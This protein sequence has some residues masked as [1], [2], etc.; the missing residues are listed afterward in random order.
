M[1]L[2]QLVLD[3]FDPPA[4]GF[5]PKQP[6]AHAGKALKAPESV[7]IEPPQK[8]PPP[9]PPPLSLGELLAPASFRHPQA[10]RE[11]RLGD[12]VVAYALQR[13]R[14]RSIG[15]TVSADGLSVRAPTGVTLAAVD[16]ALRRKS[17]WILRKLAEA[18]ERQQREEHARIRWQDGAALPYLGAPLTVVLDPAQGV[19]GVLRAAAAGAPAELRIGLPA[20]A[21]AA[22]VRDAVQAW[23]MHQARAHFT[24]RLD[25][26]APL[27]GVRWSRLRLSNAQTRWGSAKT[28]GSIRLN[29]RLLHYRPAV[30]DYVVAHELAHLRVMD[31]S[32]RFWSTVAT[33]VPDHAALRR[34]LRDEPA[35]RWD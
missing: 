18:R 21:G 1:S 22:Q 2:I 17:G 26:F 6:P 29:W 34:C 27:L 10:R 35:P 15:F 13:V 7:A 23:L 25:H 4:Q 11:L 12:A 19:A 8:S 32:P 24:E 28:D 5:T 31:H 9:P 30:I 3:L 16:D 33:V 14:R 20:S